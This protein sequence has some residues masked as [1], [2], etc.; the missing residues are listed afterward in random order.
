LSVENEFRGILNWAGS[1][2]YFSEEE[3]ARLIGAYARALCPGGY[4]L[5]EQANR[6]HVLRHRKPVVRAG[7]V[8]YRSRWNA[9][10]QQMVTRRIVNGRDDRR[11]CSV[12]RLYTPAQ[13]CALFE[14]HGLAVE[15]VH[16]SLRF[17]AYGLSVPRMV[18]VGRRKSG[19]L[20]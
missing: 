6:E 7:A 18:V 4:L 2:G 17:D 1:F 19:T 11:N 8:A 5:V 15:Q 9:R 20:K 3:N 14:R 10:K 12:M 13:M 16:E